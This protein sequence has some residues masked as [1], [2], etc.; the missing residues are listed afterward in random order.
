MSS[1]E[2]LSNK[3]RLK[4]KYKERGECSQEVTDSWENKKECVATVVTHYFSSVSRMNLKFRR[5][6]KTSQE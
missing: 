1:H 4:K 6:K 5:T 2:D 3:H